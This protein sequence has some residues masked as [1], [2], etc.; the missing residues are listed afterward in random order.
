MPLDQLE[1]EVAELIRSG[2][3]AARMDSHNKVLLAS[4]A[5]QRLVTFAHALKAG[6]SF[7]RNTKAMLLRSSLLKHKVQVQGPER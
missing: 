5:D 7:L 2:A 3:I 1:E 4:R 6:E